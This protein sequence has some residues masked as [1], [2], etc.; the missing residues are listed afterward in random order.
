MF[1][2]GTRQADSIGLLRKIGR[3]SIEK[4]EQRKSY[5]EKIKLLEEKQKE[6]RDTLERTVSSQQKRLVEEYRTA[7]NDAYTEAAKK[8]QAGK[9]KVGLN[10]LRIY[11]Q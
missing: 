4:I 2:V 7:Y 1:D 6:L 9:V 8:Y 5:E 10:G 3:L 11:E